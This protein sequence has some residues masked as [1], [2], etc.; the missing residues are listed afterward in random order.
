MATELDLTDP[1]HLALLLRHALPGFEDTTA[2]EVAPHIDA[3]RQSDNDAFSHV[4]VGKKVEEKSPW[5]DPQIPDPNQDP[6]QN[7]KQDEPSP[8]EPVQ[9]DPVE[10]KPLPGVPPK[11]EQEQQDDPFQGDPPKQEQAQQDDPFQ[12]DPPKQEPLE[13]TD[14]EASKLD[15]ESIKAK[16]K[17]PKL[18]PSKLEAPGK[19]ATD[20]P[21]DLGGVGE[22][23][24]EP[25]EVT[26]ESAGPP[27]LARRGWT[28]IDR[29]HAKGK[30]VIYA[31]EAEHDRTEPIHSKFTGRCQAVR[32]T[33]PQRKPSASAFI[34]TWLGTIEAKD[35]LLFSVE[36]VVNAYDDEFGSEPTVGH[37]ELISGARFRGRRFV[38]VAIFLAYEHAGDQKPLFYILEG[39]SAQGQ[40]KALYVSRA[41]DA[42]IQHTADFSFTPFA[43][44]SNWYDGG[45]AMDSSGSEP[46]CVYL[47]VAQQRDGRYGYLRLSAQYA[48]DDKLR[49]VIH[50][51]E[52]QIEA[53]MRVLAIAEVIG[54]ALRTKAGAD[55]TPVLG[56]VTKALLPWDE[57]PNGD[58][59]SLDRAR[60]CGCPKTR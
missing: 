25:W 45:L 5:D 12:G 31:I 17:A 48:R 28:E 57:R 47:T 22:L 14:E 23:L 21:L 40:P 13:K 56:P 7:P 26:T 49:R 38:P 53:A 9:N 11:Q 18:T 27:I 37:V 42:E 41:M 58:A 19:E 16:L 39:G 55:L 34:G 2:A 44:K 52:V 54:C 15:A 30:H 36:E 59:N 10:D 33:L 43:C 29:W 60:Y 46:A 32:V 6:A 20:L 35:H 8:D 1:E 3:L 4:G 50:P 24:Q 51:F